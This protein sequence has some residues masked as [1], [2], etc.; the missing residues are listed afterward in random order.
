[1]WEILFPRSIH[2]QH[3]NTG[4]SFNDATI[5]S[6]YIEFDIV[7]CYGSISE[8]DRVIRARIRSRDT[9]GR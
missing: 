3:R 4:I 6:G 5:V 1:M 2:D 8:I 9:N 7:L